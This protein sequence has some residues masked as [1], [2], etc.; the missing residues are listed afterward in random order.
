MSSIVISSGHGSKVRGANFYLDELDEARRVVEAV[1]DLLLKHGI[2]VKTFHD[3]ISETQSENLETIVDY[4]NQQQRD[5]DVSVHFNAYETTTKPMGCEVLY[6]TQEELA[7]DLSEAI[8]NAGGLIDRGPKYR[9]DLY[10]LNNTEAPAVLIETCFVDSSADA[11]LYLQK[12]DEICA[13]IA[14]VIAGK[15]IAV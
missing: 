5:L 10:F 15:E 13:A 6:L 7:R 9:S 11:D 14:S 3:D 8:A 1:A 4:H 12:F 2:G